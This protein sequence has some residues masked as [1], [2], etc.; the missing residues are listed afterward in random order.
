MGVV[1]VC[2]VFMRCCGCLHGP[3][4]PWCVCVCVMMWPMCRF[5]VSCLGSVL[6]LPGRFVQGELGGLCDV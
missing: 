1:D 6:G 3:G 5:V 2:C 4:A